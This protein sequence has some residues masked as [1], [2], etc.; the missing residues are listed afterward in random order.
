MLAGPQRFIVGRCLV[1]VYASQVDLPG[2]A[3]WI[4]AW[5]IYRLPR[6]DGDEPV[7][8]GDTDSEAS[9]GVA[10]GMAKAIASQVALSL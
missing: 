5:A 9:E 3:G 2:V 1:H 4:G 6:R 8:I 7:R 10:L